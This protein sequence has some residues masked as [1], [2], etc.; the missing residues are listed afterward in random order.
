MTSSATAADCRATTAH[1]IKAAPAG[2]EV[3]RRLA[4]LPP[5]KPF[6]SF[7]Q[8]QNMMFV[9]AG[10]LVEQ[11]TGESWENFIQREVFDRLNMT[12]SNFSVETMQGMENIAMPYRLPERP[13]HAHPLCQRG[14][15]RPSRLDQLH[16][17]RYAQLGAPAPQPGHL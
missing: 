2:E 7:Y 8:Y 1:G 15:P 9:T 12:R 17:D 16:N 5:N 4:N 3:V 13:D 14:R 10:F 11:I 6:R